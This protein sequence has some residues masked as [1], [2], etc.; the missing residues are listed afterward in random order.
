MDFFVGPRAYVHKLS[1]KIN[2]YGTDAVNQIVKQEK[3][4]INDEGILNN[5][6]LTCSNTIFCHAHTSLFS[7]WKIVKTMHVDESES[8]WSADKNHVLWF[9]HV[10]NLLMHTHTYKL[11]RATNPNFIIAKITWISFLRRLRVLVACTSF[12]LVPF[13]VFEH[14]RY[15]Y[16]YVRMCVIRTIVTESV[17]A[18]RNINNQMEF[19]C[20]RWFFVFALVVNRRQSIH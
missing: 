10:H 3:R 19:R 7:F 15:Y 8:I 2:K 12:T 4:K 11:K 16:T 20:T 17:Q 14:F 1:W 18:Q 9:E 6:R 13:F 5:S